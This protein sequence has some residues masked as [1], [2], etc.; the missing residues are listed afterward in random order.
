MFRGKYILLVVLLAF[1]IGCKKKDVVPGTSGTG[2]GGNTG[3]GSV[4]TTNAVIPVSAATIRECFNGMK[5]KDVHPR[6]LFSNADITR[7]KETSAADAFA[8]SNYDDIISRA[9]AL[10]G[11]A[12]PT[13]A[14]DGAGLRIPSIHTVS[15]DQ[16]PYLVLAYQF[17]KDARYA[18]KCWQQVDA[19]C[20]F[21]DWGANRHFL[22]AGIAAKGVAIALDGLWDY[23]SSS[24]RLRIY[25]TVK[26]FVLQPGKTQIETNTGVWKWYLSDDNWN[27][28]CHGGML[29]AALAGYEYDSTFNSTVIAM[30][31]NGIARYMQSLEP[32][33]AS[34]EGM[35]YW[36]YGLNNTF[37]AFESLKRCLSTTYGLAESAGFKKTGWFPYQVSGPVGTVSIGDDYLYNGKTNKFLSYFWFAKYFNDANLAKTH[38]D[39]CLAVNA[40]R[41]VKMNGW[42]DLLFYPKELVGSGSSTQAPL[43]GYIRGLEYMYVLEKHNDDNA[44]YV[45]IHG[46]DNASSHGHLDAG[47]FYLQALGENFGI[48]NLGRQDPYPADYFTVTNPAY[49]SAPTNTAAA[50][51]RFYYYRIKTES[52]NC[53]V[54]NPDA[55]P[56]QNPAGKASLSK[57]DLDASGG[58]FLLDLRD[59]YTRDVNAYRRGIKLNRSRGLVTVQDEFTP[60]SSSL[61]YWLMQT[62]ASD[63]ITLSPDGKTATMVRNGKTIYAVLKA[64]ATAVFEKVDRSASTVLYLN[65]TAPIF[66]TLMS[67]K[68]SLNP[69]YGKL[70][71]RLTGISA[72]TTIRVD[73]VTSLTTATTDLVPLDNWTTTN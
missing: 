41:T 18:A 57:S 25:N 65:E 19:L 33:G 67:G 5:T 28:I 4:F 12:L 63:G 49:T 50:T 35:S 52:K 27:G 26:S 21:P 16:I 6:L 31:A 17:T 39:A 68:N 36:A 42:T 3:G 59:C 9:N 44:L 71:I 55:R 70:Q 58:F 13:Y 66:G 11:A 48:G 24:Q 47:S 60:K 8:K 22:D 37:L 7:I 34:E 54:F 14:L 62:P 46:G 29:M 30:S 72:A 73:F 23:L 32:D 61:V 43:G 40:S 69:F 53:L 64:P 56:E 38:Y 45:G 1:A 51:G 15:N 10:L 2:G 20:G